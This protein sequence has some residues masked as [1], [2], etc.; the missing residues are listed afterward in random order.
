M[1]PIENSLGGSIHAVYDLLLRY[2]LHIVGETSVAVKHC[3]L[4]LPGTQLGDLTR[5]LSHPQVRAQ[6]QKSRADSSRV[7]SDS[8]RAGAA[9]RSMQPS[10]ACSPLRPCSRTA[11]QHGA[12]QYRVTARALQALAQTDSYLRKLNVVKEAVDDTAG[13]A[14]MVAQQQLKVR[15]HAHRSGQSLSARDSSA[16]RSPA[17]HGA[18]H[19]PGMRSLAASGFA[20]CV[21]RAGRR[22]GREPAR[23]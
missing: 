12:M 2:R 9:V 18:A 23:C 3:L 7:V 1:L 8:N 14:Q 20:L 16:S 17:A 6:E 4:A 21:S 10:R 22:R 11:T 13:A 5:V 15:A 19:P